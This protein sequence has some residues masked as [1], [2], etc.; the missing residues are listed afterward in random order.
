[1]LKSKHN[2]NLR[3]NMGEY[4]EWVTVQAGEVVPKDLEAQFIKGGGEEL[5]VNE[6]KQAVIEVKPVEK[7]KKESV[8]E[9]KKESFK[10]KITRLVKPRTKKKK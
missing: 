8:K 3:R 7:A 5:I 4:F 6:V 10:E 2:V 1:M 9:V